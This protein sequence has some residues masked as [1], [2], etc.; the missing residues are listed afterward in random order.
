[1]RRAVFW[2]VALG[3]IVGGNCAAWSQSVTPGPTPANSPAGAPGS[4]V[5]PQ[6]PPKLDSA[7]QGSTNLGSTNPGSTSQAASTPV[8]AGGKLHGVVKSG[9]ITLPGVTVTAQNTLTGKRYS[10]T[11]D[12][13]GAWSMSIPQ[14]GR[15]VIR[16]Q[17]AAFAPG[18]QE[19]VLNATNHDQTV[20]FA[21]IGFASCA[22]AGQGV[23]ESAGRQFDCPA[24]GGEQRAKPK[25]G[26]RVGRRTRTR[27]T[28]GR[29]WRECGDCGSGA[30]FDC[31]QLRLRRGF[32]GHQRAV[33]PGESHG[34]SGH[35]SDS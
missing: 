12:I 13:A 17:F 8:I 23:S 7:N 34:R 30:A 29:D 5:A 31:R 32:G 6:S 22:A 4:S 26:E 19:A 20:T 2:A 3:T 1:M 27:H 9:N 10:T 28:S 35:R 18:S 33:G 15:Y 14:N 11:T 25:P 16:T 24:T 21:L